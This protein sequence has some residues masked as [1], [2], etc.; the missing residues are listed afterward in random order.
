MSIMLEKARKYEIEAMKQIEEGQKPSFHVCAPIGWINDPNGF[1]VYKGEY[2][3]FYQYHPY[4]TAWGPMHWGHSKSKDFI[5]WEQLPCAMAPDREYDGQGCFSGSAVEHEGTHVLMYT[6]VLDKVQEDGTKRLA[7]TQCIAIGDGEN[8]KKLNNNPI[9]TSTSLPK[10]SSKEDFRDPKIWKEGE[11]FYVILGSRREGTGG[12]VLL[13]KSQDAQKWEYVSIVEESENQY[14]N[15]WECPDF[16]SLGGKQLLLISPMAM[17]AK[18]LEFHNGNNSIYFIGE[19]DR[20]NYKLNREHVALIDYGL[21]FYAPQTL[22]TA[23]GRRIMI[24]WMQ[25]WDNY[26]TPPDFKWSGLMTVP[27]ELHLKEGVL[28]QNPVQEIEDYYQ[29]EVRYNTITICDS[30]ELSGVQGRQFD[31]LVEIEEGEYEEF[32]IRFAADADNE[33]YSELQYNAKINT[34]TFDRTYSGIRKDILHKRA[35]HVKGQKGKVKIRV[36]MD[37][38]S[39]EIFVNDGEQAMSS[40][41]YTPIEANQIY[42]SSIGGAICN[43]IKYDVVVQ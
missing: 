1:S 29:N 24:A 12:Q 10:G 32:S 5:K 6:G 33:Y 35:M 16:F 41:I 20:D 23:D 13:F 4:S 42:F 17:L 39:V 25:S 36:L 22:E 28:Y 27:R 40:L 37:K 30:Q 19:Y 43:I 9:I 21:D 26:I 8:Y 11:V 34:I 3:L 18:G 15:M 31:L 14:G 38:Y 2:H 7:Q